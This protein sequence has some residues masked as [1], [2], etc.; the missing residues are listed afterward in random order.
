MCLLVNLLLLS[1][2]AAKLM[3]INMTYLWQC[4]PP[5]PLLS[6]GFICSEKKT[7]R[8]YRFWEVTQF[9]NW[10]LSAVYTWHFSRQKPAVLCLCTKQRGLKYTEHKPICR[11]C[12]MCNPFFYE[13]RVCRGCCFLYYS[14]RRER[15]DRWERFLR[16]YR[17]TVCVTIDIPVCVTIDIPVCVT[18][19]Q[20]LSGDWRDLGNI[21][22]F[23]IGADSVLFVATRN[24]CV[25]DSPLT[26]E[27]VFVNV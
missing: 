4:C 12:K 20:D 27:S 25:E 23:Q 6:T 11:L 10:Y 9:K 5:S 7:R 14:I 8:F 22:T 3:R 24:I 19:L 15:T 1:I 16:G 2:V 13:F 18:V 17:H 21:S 26:P